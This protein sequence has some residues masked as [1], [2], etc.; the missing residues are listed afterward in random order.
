V[1][2]QVAG[3]RGRAVTHAVQLTERMQAGRPRRAEQTLPGRSADADHAREPG[4]WDPKP[5]DRFSALTS[6]S[7]SRTLSSLPGSM[8]RVRNI[9][10]EVSGVRIGWGSAGCITCPP[11][12]PGRSPTLA[13]PASAGLDASFGYVSSP[14]AGGRPLPDR[15]GGAWRSRPRADRRPDRLASHLRT[16]VDAGMRRRGYERESLM[17]SSCWSGAWSVSRGRGG[18]GSPRPGRTSTRSRRPRGS[19]HAPRQGSRSLDC[20]RSR[21]AR[22]RR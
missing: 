8:V 7:T 2:E 21:A 15:P 10:A 16:S 18:T 13:R 17:P 22:A 4:L 14:R 3:R 5:T 12:R 9:A 11:P 6:A 20:V 19:P 1:E